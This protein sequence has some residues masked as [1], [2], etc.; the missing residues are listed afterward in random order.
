MHKILTDRRVFLSGITGLAGAMALQGSIGSQPAVVTEKAPKLDG[1][2]W[3]NSAKGVSLHESRG[4]VT[5]VHFWTYGCINCKRNLPIYTRWQEQFAARQVEVVGIHSPE[6]PAEAVAKNVAR[7]TT[8]F[9]ITYPVLLDPNLVNWRRWKQQYW[10]A[11]YLVDRQGRIRYR[12]EGE[13]N[14]ATLDG[15][16]KM[17][18]LINQLSEEIP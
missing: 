14:Y 12:W 2:E 18:A 1:N 5:V 16:R 6:F 9:G 15:E 4:L 3:L 7:K 17:T 10:P 13:M 8:E 11:A